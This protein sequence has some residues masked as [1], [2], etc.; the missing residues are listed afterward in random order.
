MAID[1]KNSMA[2]PYAI[3]IGNLSTQG[4]IVSKTIKLASFTTNEN[5]V[6]AARRQLQKESYPLALISIPVNRNLFRLEV[7]DCFKFS[8]E[9]YDISNMIC[10]VVQIAEESL[11]SET[12]T[13][14]AVEDVF[15]VTSTI[16]GGGG[17]VSPEPPVHD[18]PGPLKFIKIIEESYAGVESENTV[19]IP[20]AGRNALVELGFALYMSIDDGESYDLIDYY[21]SLMPRGTLVGAYPKDTHTIDDEVGI[22]VDFDFSED[23]DNLET[24]TFANI[25]AAHKNT[26]IL[27]NEILSIQSITPDVDNKY[28]LETIIRG[29]FGAQKQSHAAGTVFWFLDHNLKTAIGKEIIPGINRKFKLVPYDSF[30]VGD[31]SVVEV[32]SFDITG[33]TKTPYS[34][35]NLTANDGNYV[36]QY[37]A[38]IVLEWDYRYRGVGA[39]IG[40]PGEVLPETDKDG[41]FR[42]EVWVSGSKARDTDGITA[43]TWTYT[44]AMNEAD[45]GALADVAQFKVF[46]YIETEGIIYESEETEVTCRFES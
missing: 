29:R 3:D 41:L 2:S 24:T 1:F 25:L 5:A 37:T 46:N 11:S 4:R 44:Q 30:K 8:Y 28:I 40:V 23:V 19:L 31:I 21:P 9:K 17:G 22:T 43:A 12:I 38:D 42:I 45:N 20:V 35:T 16:T 6:W 10:R 36:S 13:I 34:V 7:G 15:A 14:H 26:A 33:V 39:G 32:I 18:P 27:G